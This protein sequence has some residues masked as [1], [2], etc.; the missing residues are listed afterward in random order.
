MSSDTGSTRRPEVPPM[1]MMESVAVF[2]GAGMLLYVATRWAIPALVASTGMR[3]L[4]AW[5]AAGGL[6]VFLPLLVIAWVLMRREPRRTWGELWIDRFRF[7][8]MN[9][10]D[11]T[12]CGA[13]LTAVLALSG[14]ILAAIRTLRPDARLHPEF[15]TMEPLQADTLWLLAVWLPFFV[16]NVASE[17]ILWRGVVLPRQGEKFGRSAWFVHGLGWLLFHVPFGL[18]ILLTLA[19]TVWIIPWTVQ[20]RSNSWIGVSVHAG[21]NGLGFL[22]VAAGL[23]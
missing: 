1:G 7:R 12:A 15:L 3:P 18:T 6:G 21:L 14:L 23:V 22:A 2:G 10:G 20:R 16:L 9:R 4:L 8:P 19:P 11:L 13:A 5:F 17:E